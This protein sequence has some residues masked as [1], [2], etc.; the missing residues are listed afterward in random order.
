MC[1]LACSSFGL[2]SASICREQT[3]AQRHPGSLSIGCCPA[4][5]CQSSILLLV[6][7]LG[8]GVHNCMPSR[9]IC[10]SSCA[11]GH[12]F[13]RATKADCIRS[14]RLH[15]GCHAWSNRFDASMLAEV[16][17]FLSQAE[18][19]YLCALISESW[20]ASKVMP[21]AHILVIDL[22]QSQR[23]AGI[24]R[25]SPKQSHAPALPG[26]APPFRGGPLSV[27]Y[28]INGCSS[29]CLGRAAIEWDQLGR[30]H[31]AFRSPC[32]CSCQS[33][34]LQSQTLIY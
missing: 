26:G 1:S 18:C 30:H 22:K 28:P 4:E 9:Q 29:L 34:S 2:M 24:L 23:Q 17:R 7:G 33:A 19:A 3:A 13:A 11:A 27:C 14:T 8:N 15:N 21:L 32:H 16:Q 5:G 25:T 31:F 12:A 10:C 6:A 20:P